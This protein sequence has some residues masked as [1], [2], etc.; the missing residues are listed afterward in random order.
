MRRRWVRG[1]ALRRR[2]L[3]EEEIGRKRS[4]KQESV[5]EEKL[6]KKRSCKEERG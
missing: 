6:W 2:V 3:E 1:E 5:L 4:C